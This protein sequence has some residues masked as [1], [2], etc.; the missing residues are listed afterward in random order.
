MGLLK[1]LLQ[2][3]KDGGLLKR[4]VTLKNYEIEDD[5]TGEGKKKAVKPSPTK[6]SPT[7]KKA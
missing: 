5:D 6:P 3:Q 1:R 7:R 4:A 2:E